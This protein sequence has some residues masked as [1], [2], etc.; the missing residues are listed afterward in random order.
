MV[1]QGT[2]PVSACM[3]YVLVAAV[4]KPCE[5]LCPPVSSGYTHGGLAARGLGRLSI[6][7]RE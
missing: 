5:R 4:P 1:L 3:S 2:C 6:S 7:V